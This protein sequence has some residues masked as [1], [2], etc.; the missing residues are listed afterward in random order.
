[1]NT[2]LLAMGALCMRER[3]SANTRG[4]PGQYQ[5]EVHGAGRASGKFDLAKWKLQA[6]AAKACPIS[7]N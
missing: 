2:K 3:V 6:K 5:D 4:T 7:G 1:M